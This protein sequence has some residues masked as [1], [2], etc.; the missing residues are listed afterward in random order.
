MCLKR[1]GSFLIAV[2]LLA[3]T[4]GCGS[5]SYTLTIFSS[6]GGAVVNPGEGA[7]IYGEGT[8]VN[9]VAEAD[10]GYYFVNWTGDVSNIANVN[11]VITTIIM[12][13]S[14]EIT[15][16]F[17]Q[18]PPGQFGLT[19]SSTSGG[20]VNIPGEATFTYD[21]GAVVDLVAETEEG[22]RFVNW[23]GDVGTIANVEAATTNITMN[24]DYSI[25]ANFV[26]LYDLTISSTTGGSVATP[27]E[28]TSTYDEGTVVN[29][30]AEVDESYRFVNWT[31][32]VETIGNVNAA[33]TTI[34]MN[35][36]Y[37]IIANFEE[38]PEYDLTLSSTEGGSVTS[39]G[40]GTLAYD[41]ETVVIL[42]AKAEEGYY[43]ANWSGDVGIITNIKARITAI[44]I[45]DNYSI[46]A[47]FEPG[48]MPVIA[49][50]SWHTV[51]LKSDS[52]VVA[53]GNNEYGQ[54]N[55]TGWTG[56][57]QVAAGWGHT[58][59]LKADGTVVA[60]GWNDYGQCNVG[61]WTHII[62]VDA[63][64]F[65][66]VGLKSDDTV[67]A[68]GRNNYGQC[69][70][71]SWTDIIQ[72]SADYGDH[73]VGLQ[74]DGTVV[75]VGRNDYGQCNVNGW[76]GIIQVSAGGS[77]TVGLKSDGTV[78]AVGRNDHGQCN[79]SGWTDIIQIA[80]GGVFTVGLKSDG[81]VVAVGWND[82][83]QCNVS[84]WTDIIQISAGGAHTVGL[85]S[86]G[87]LVAVGQNY[88]GQCNV[89]GWDL[90]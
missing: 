5:E 11:A 34:T 2:A 44:T 76:T 63:S 46:T 7:F 47:N 38:I 85:K 53:V 18:I 86:N 27:G 80:T 61:G 87:T 40:E 84:G 56:I 48:Y 41:E 67:V 16:N 9:L 26:A 51:G 23:T 31:G 1:I 32:D 66:T 72:V 88:H 71:N 17:D 83:G 10:E 89:G 3:G 52:T 77:H 90:N 49:T 43:F 74:S 24:G 60:A 65:H 22:Y 62:Q 29:L 20:L 19:V 55:I 58:V 59:G 36:N 14:Y 45:Y 39:P 54:C 78:I 25:T 69:N 6:A 21:E 35:G 37:Y 13:D 15:A 82:D 50:G 75:A 68:V 42:L 81:T 4:V 70:V 64:C 79:V 33:M 12:N 8:V 30:V 57:V 73:T 28:G